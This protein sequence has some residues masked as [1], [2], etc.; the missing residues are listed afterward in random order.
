MV[1]VFRCAPQLSPDLGSL[2]DIEGVSF[3]PRNL[4]QIHTRLS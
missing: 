1:V 3:R 2:V 4:L